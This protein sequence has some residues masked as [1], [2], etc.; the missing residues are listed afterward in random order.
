MLSYALAASVLAALV[1]GVL[2]LER[3]GRGVAAVEPGVEEA[4][5]DLAQRLGKVQE[6]DRMLN[7]GNVRLASLH[8]PNS[9]AA[10][11][12]YLVWDY[13]TSQWH[14]FASQLPPAPAGKTYQLWAI[15]GDDA[16]LAGPTF[17]VDAAGFGS[18]V[19]DFPQLDPGSR[20]VKAVVTLEPESGST[21]PTSEALLEAVVTISRSPSI[22]APRVG[23]LVR[24][25]H[26][27]A[28][29]APVA[30]RTA[31]LGVAESP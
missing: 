21:A 13:A 18:V 9:A 30:R 31:G 19:A 29:I 20:D 17:A 5:R 8:A 27:Y 4:L 3:P 23:A 25:V 28:A 24:P 11:G 2:Y 12:A 7:A 26:S 22:A 6:L 14:F 15:T 16:P 1:G 10:A